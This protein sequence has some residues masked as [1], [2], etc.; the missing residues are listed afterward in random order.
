MALAA[1]GLS[2]HI[3]NNN[4]RSIA[5]LAAYPLAILAIVWAISFAFGYLQFQGYGQDALRPAIAM[6]N[7]LLLEYWPLVVTIVLIWFVIAWFSHTAMI[8]RLS[9]SRPVSRSEEPELY[10][11]LENLCI[12]R[13]MPMPRLEI[14]E[15]HARNAFASGIDDRSYTVT[16]TRGLLNSLRKDEIEAVLAH[17]LTHI[18][19]RDVRLLIV[20]IIFTGMIGILAQMV[21]S[22]LRYNLYFGR[23]K[24]RNSGAMLL[25]MLAVGAILSIG[26]IATLL[27][28][29]ALTRGREYMA[30][31][32]A[33]ELTKNPQAM[34]RALMRISRHERIPGATEDIAMMYTHNSS[35]FLGLFATHP[36]IEDRIKTLSELTGTPVPE[37]SLAPA[38]SEERFGN[39]SSAPNPWS[40]DRRNR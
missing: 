13:G 38:G 22:S 1:A 10:N 25:I 15:T 31:A 2:T 8:R 16:I 17:E 19:N 11:I 32:G 24:N 27:T 34:M 14:I 4:L 28:R 23:S 29:F 37:L 30:D 39:R 7:S 12:S 40:R 26:Y 18:A 36:P 9:H 33:V 35:P 3:W 6:G 5:L 21:W 20:S